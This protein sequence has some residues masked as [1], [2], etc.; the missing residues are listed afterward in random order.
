MRQQF[1]LSHSQH[2]T[3][4]NLSYRRQSVAPSWWMPTLASIRQLPTPASNKAS[5]SSSPS[6]SEGNIKCSCQQFILYLS[7][8]FFTECPQ[9]VVQ[10]LNLNLQVCVCV[11]ACVCALCHLCAHVCSLI[12]CYCMLFSVCDFWEKEDWIWNSWEVSVFM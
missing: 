5:L 11:C 7:L 3:C 10:S 4:L 8:F 9:L 12:I 6:I 2:K 1:L